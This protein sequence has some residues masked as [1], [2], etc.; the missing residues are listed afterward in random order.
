[1]IVP[2]ARFATDNEWD[3]PTLDIT[4]QARYVDMPFVAWGSRKRSSEHCGTYHFYVDDYRFTALWKDPS[5]LLK[6]RCV[7]AVEPN[8]TNSLDSPKAYVLWSIYQKRWM[9]RYW[10]SCGVRIWVDLNVPT[11]FEDLLFLGVPKQWRA[12]MTHG[13][14]DRLDATVNE[15]CAACTHHGNDDILFTV[16]GGG[17]EVKQMCND[18][19]WVWVAER[20]DRVQ[21]RIIA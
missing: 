11:E 6:S 10:Q 4:M 12:Y 15:Y 17:H 2:N 14:S 1:M 7:A 13:Y 21:G 3:I 19:G 9:A 18:H 20:M 8:I 5:K 16:Y